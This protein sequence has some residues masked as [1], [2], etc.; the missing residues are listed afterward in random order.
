VARPET[1]QWPQRHDAFAAAADLT[2]GVEAIANDHRH[3]TTVATVGKVEVSPNSITTIAGHAAVY[4]DVRD[5]DSDR[6]RET[7][8]RLTSERRGKVT[9]TVDVVV[10]GDGP[11]GAVTARS[12]AQAGVSVAMIGRSRRQQ[13]VGEGL[14][15]AANPLLRA[16][17]LWDAFCNDGHL[18]SY[19]NRSLWGSAVPQ[20]TDFIRSP[21]GHGWHL[22]RIRFEAMLISAA[23]DAGVQYHPH[24][25]LLDRHR[26]AGTGRRLTV[27]MGFIHREIHTA[28]LIDATGRARRV[29]RSLES[30]R[31]AYDR[32]IGI[33][34]RFSPAP[35]V[36]DQDSVTL[37]EAVRSGWWYASL[38]PTSQLIV[39]YMT[40]ADLAGT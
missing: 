7:A 12:L 16:L 13:L 21:R 8:N 29:A 3:R 9:M 36:M 30:E 15:P 33:V 37:V 34:G 2:P 35:G 18:P 10:V 25:R 24:C 5:I 39:S 23:R 40:D 19:R 20:E 11:A 28:F 32:L 38:L 26:I 22:D 14:P 4:V 27:L 31:V 17:G 1:V 6:Q